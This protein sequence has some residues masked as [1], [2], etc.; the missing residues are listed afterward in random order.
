MPFSAYLL[1][2][3]AHPHENQSFDALVKALAPECAGSPE[4]HYL[5]GNVMF[6]GD[7][8]DA[9]FLKSG[10]IAV[11][12]MK[13]Y[14]GRGYFSQK[15]DWDAGGA[16]VRGTRR[17][18][19]LRPARRYKF[20]LL[21]YLKRRE[22]RILKSPRNVIWHH[23]QGMVLF[24]QQIH[25][26]EHLPPN[27]KTWF[28]I[29]DHRTVA[30]DLCCR[31]S[32][33]LRLA[34]P[35]LAEILRCLEVHDGHRYAG[36]KP[37][38]PQPVLTATAP[39]PGKIRVVIHKESGFRESWLRA[40]ESG[41]LKSDG[42]VQIQLLLDE[43]RRGINALARFQP[44]VDTRVPGCTIYT[45]NPRCQLLLFRV[46]NFI[47]PWFVGNPEEVASWLAANEGITLV[48]DGA[49]QRIVATVVGKP[50]TEG[51]VE[52]PTS[53]IENLPFLARLPPLHLASLV[54]KSLVRRQLLDLTEESSEAEIVEVLELVEDEALR[55]FLFD[56]INLLRKND[57]TGA[58]ARVR[59]PQ[60]DACP[61]EDAAALAQGAVDSGVNS[62]Q[63]LELQ[64]KEE[65][66]LVLDREIG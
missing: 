50:L 10:C 53:T 4:P 13:N 6:D 32:A 39:Q 7:E 12:E 28:Q 9:I 43:L 55:L 3:F 18:H 2:G 60:G 57:L 31:H 64:Q 54:A 27:I 62:D 59:L 22:D 37:T 61:V 65:L 1:S 41:T 15:C 24:G 45:I 21:D 40:N 11:I 66:D 42:A 17:G 14:G 63:L 30:R 23:I 35:E 44:A 49:T 56:V 29:C 25:F 47:Y 16:V 51:N 26:D 46:G 20:T 33:A 48:V 52:R 19:P 8:L 36:V 5:L 34:P 38:G 58:E